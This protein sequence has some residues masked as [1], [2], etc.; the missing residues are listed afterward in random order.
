MKRP[1]CSIVFLV[2]ML[3]LLIANEV[4]AQ[5]GLIRS[6]GEGNILRTRGKMFGPNMVSVSFDTA[7][8]YHDKY[9][10]IYRSDEE[11]LYVVSAK[12]E[13]IL[14]QAGMGE[15]LL[16]V[17]F[18]DD[19]FKDIV[20]TFKSDAPDVKALLLFDHNTE[21]FKPVAGFDTYPEPVLID[22][23][24]LYYSYAPGGCA[25]FDWISDLFY[26]KDYEAIK[27]GS[28]TTN[29]CPDSEPENGIYIRK[30]REGQM[31]QIDKIPVTVFADYPDGK[32]GF[33]NSYWNK[34]YKKFK[35]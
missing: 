9:Y 1:V 15:N 32:W 20:V 31:E 7:T 22:G 18:N 28:M 4:S 2:S 23:T 19:G 13:I 5:E 30:L 26:I 35:H 34:N 16:F 12:R 17:D 14:K 3:L 21:T 6:A 27:T 8:V 25:G 29:Q 10:A 24:N 33:L 11:L